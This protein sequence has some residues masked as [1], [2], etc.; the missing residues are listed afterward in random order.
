MNKPLPRIFAYV[1]LAVIGLVFAFYATT[2]AT[3]GIAA[4]LMGRTSGGVDL[5]SAGTATLLIGIAMFAAFG[6]LA[7]RHGWTEL[8]QRR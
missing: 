7:L 3:G 4:G 8:K 1:G 2:I 6:Y 5:L